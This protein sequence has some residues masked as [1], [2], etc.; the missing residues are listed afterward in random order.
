MSSQAAIDQ[1]LKL[2]ARIAPAGYFVGLHIRFTSPLMTFQTY[3]QAWMDHYT[4][5]G[6]VLRDP[7]TAWG[8]SKTGWIRWS[9]PALIDPFGVFAEAA[10][11]GLR[12]GATVSYGPISSRTIGSRRSPPR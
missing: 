3:D 11:F 8:F 10:T 4:D 9:D 6:Y 1:Q 7:M 5:N 2:L 12:H